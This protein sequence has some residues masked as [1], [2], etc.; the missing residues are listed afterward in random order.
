LQA[1][2]FR[3]HS[4]GSRG[5]R[6]KSG[7]PDA[8]QGLSRI[9]GSA[10]GTTPIF[11][12]RFLAQLDRWSLRYHDRAANLWNLMCLLERELVEP[13]SPDYGNLIEQA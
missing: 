12:R 7:R 1:V 6:F 4:W 3:K 11:L 13:F 9:L 8:G 2:A 10:L 5:R